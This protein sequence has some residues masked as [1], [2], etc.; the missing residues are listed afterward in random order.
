MVDLRQ[1][2]PVIPRSSRT[3]IVE[4]CLKRSPLWPYFIVHKL[5]TNTRAKQTDQAVPEWLLK[6][7]NGTLASPDRDNLSARHVPDSCNIVTSDIVD[8]VFSDVQN[9]RA[10]ANRVILTSTN[11]DS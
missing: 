6:L 7:G 4:Q 5:A 10:L 11:T 8:N 9:V 3:V 2:L 1:V